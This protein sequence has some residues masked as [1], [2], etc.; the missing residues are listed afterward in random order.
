M[1]WEPPDLVGE[2]YVFRFFFRFQ[3]SVAGEPT[4]PAWSI[5]WTWKV[6]FPFFTLTV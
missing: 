3:V 1:G 6:C 4:F 2:P 5:A